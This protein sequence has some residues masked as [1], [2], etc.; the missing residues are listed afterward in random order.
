MGSDIYTFAAPVTF[1]TEKIGMA[2]VVRK[3]GVIKTKSGIMCMKLRI[4]KET[5]WYS[6]MGESS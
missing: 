5:C 6:A 4:P 3:A 1:G 2:V